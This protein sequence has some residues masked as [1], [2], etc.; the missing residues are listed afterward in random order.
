MDELILEV[1]NLKTYYFLPSGIIKAV[2][3]LSFNIG[4]GKALGII[5]ESGSGKSTIA[6]SILR[7]LP[8][9]GKIVNGEIL[10]E[11]QNIL[12]FTEEEM[13]KF[14]W[15]K[16]SLV[17]QFA[18]NALDP[19]MRIGDQIVEAILINEDIPKIKAV[20]RAKQL[21]E[22]VR[23]DKSRFNDYPHTLSGGMRQRVMIAMALA[24]NPG[25]I[26]ADEPT[27]ALDVIVQAQILN[28][29]NELKS[30]MK[31]SSIILISHDL[32]VIV[33]L[34][35]KI[36][37]MYG[38][39]LME[40]ANTETIIN[41]PLHPYTKALINSFPNIE[42]KEVS[43]TSIPGN[44]PNMMNIPKGCLFYPRCKYKKPICNEKNP[45]ILNLGN[46]HL[47]ACHLG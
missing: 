6:W 30:G 27:T 31:S 22:D 43:F 10:Y 14:S 2:D 5:G 4:K 34:C 45:E 17:T 13:R 9:P 42:E 37:I 18:M 32:S 41:K 47:V 29:L 24:S 21:F 12:E 25:I 33:E 36:V 7:A 46:D 20:E 16:I 8:Y 15:K 3:G 40:S 44:P 38:G 11:G 1:K 35:D 39:K 23:I 19:L 26:I 28:L